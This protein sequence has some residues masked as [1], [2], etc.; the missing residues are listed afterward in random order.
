MYVEENSATTTTKVYED[1]RINMRENYPIWIISYDKF[2]M[3]IEIESQALSRSKITT[4]QAVSFKKFGY[5]YCIFEIFGS[6]KNYFLILSLL[7]MIN[8][9]RK[10]GEGNYN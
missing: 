7:S 2:A 5:T 9:W 6:E 8:L 10:F 1:I 3:D 4:I